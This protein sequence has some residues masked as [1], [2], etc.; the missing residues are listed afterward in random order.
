MSEAKKEK[1]PSL[2]ENFSSLEDIITQ[3][4][5]QEITLDESFALYQSG[6]K[7]LKNCSNLIDE[8]EKKMQVLNEE[9]ELE[10]FS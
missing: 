7:A 1:T 9:G 5:S 8:V 3:L 10:E 2:E 4:E 6:V